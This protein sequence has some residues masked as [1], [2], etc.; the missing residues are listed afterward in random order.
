MD[1]YK[2]TTEIC[3][4]EKLGGLYD[5]FLSNID[6]EIAELFEI[7]TVK[8]GP[9]IVM[10]KQKDYKEKLGEEIGTHIISFAELTPNL[11]EE[12]GVEKA[13][14]VREL[15]GDMIKFAEEVCHI[16]IIDAMYQGLIGK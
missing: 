12:Y 16:G 8:K 2:I 5:A 9:P 3:G 11:I 1:L 6:G 7:Y 14:A 15:A 13:L 4:N 10:P